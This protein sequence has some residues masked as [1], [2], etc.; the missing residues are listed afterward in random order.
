MTSLLQED[1]QTP[2]PI[3]YDANHLYLMKIALTKETR[4][5]TPPQVQIIYSKDDL[6]HQKLGESS[7]YRR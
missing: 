5:I 7:K 3:F 1:K 2:F 4:I 6:S